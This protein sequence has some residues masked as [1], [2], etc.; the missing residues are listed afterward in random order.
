MCSRLPKKCVRDDL[1]LHH[2][3]QRGKGQALAVHYLQSYQGLS[4]EYFKCCSAKQFHLSAA[5]LR[6]KKKQR[7]LLMSLQLR[8]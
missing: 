5:T 6:Q 7:C 8:V 1:P 3:Q 2:L 4:N